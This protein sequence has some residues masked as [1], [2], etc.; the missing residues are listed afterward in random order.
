MDPQVE[1]MPDSAPLITN[2]MIEAL[3]HH[4]QRQAKARESQDYTQQQDNTSLPVT[5]FSSPVRTDKEVITIPDSPK[6]TAATAA[7]PLPKKITLQEYQD[8]KAQEEALAATFLD[9]DE[10]FKMLDYEDFSS[11][12]DPV[13]IHIGFWTPTPAPEAPKPMASS[14]PT[15]VPEITV[16]PPSHHPTVAANRAPGYDQGMALSNALPMH[17]AHY[18]SGQR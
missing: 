7:A 8:C 13:N 9:R 3:C 10:H 15:I 12:D 5:D 16:N 17:I 2:G 1:P 18:F 6:G 11:Q 4:D 14:R